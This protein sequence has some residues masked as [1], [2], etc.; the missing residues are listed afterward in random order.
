MVFGHDPLVPQAVMDRFGVR[1][2]DGRQGLF[3]AIIITVAHDEFR[4]MTLPEIRKLLSDH[5]V[6]VDVRGM[7][8][9][10]GA[11]SLGIHY[12]RL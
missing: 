2:W 12:Q 5:P 1:P 9:E 4:K 8:D 10:E 6:L 3:D 7:V 11:R